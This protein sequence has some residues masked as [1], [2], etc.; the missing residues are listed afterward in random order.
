[1][2]SYQAMSFALIA[3]LVAALP[4][5]LQSSVNTVYRGH[6]PSSR[7]GNRGRD[8]ADG[9]MDGPVRSDPF[10]RKKQA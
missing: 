3:S 6:G 10:S 2:L 4:Y 8:R 5:R 9:Q 7:G 1:M